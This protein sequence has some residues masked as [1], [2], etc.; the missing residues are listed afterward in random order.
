MALG[1]LLVGGVQA[2]DWNPWAVPDQRPPPTGFH[3]PG[4]SRFV[5]PD[6]D[7]TQDRRRRSGEGARPAQP[8]ISWGYSGSLSG[9]LYAP[10]VL[11][12]PVGGDPRGEFWS[13]G[14]PGIPG[15]S[16]YPGVLPYGGYPGGSMLYPG[17][18]LGLFSPL[19][20]S[21]LGGLPL[22]GQP[23]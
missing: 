11:D 17:T 21:P 18:G 5:A 2:Q 7:P 15:L 4:D 23:Y 16:T 6:Y 13:P 8:G 3:S 12:A 1:V 19:Y 20:G 10:P 14:V 9:G 22:F